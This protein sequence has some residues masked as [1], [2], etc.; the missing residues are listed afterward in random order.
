[1]LC[2][3]GCLPL[4]KH[5]TRITATSSTLIDHIY[6]NATTQ[7]ITS[8]IITSDLSDHMPV[9]VLIQ[10]LHKKTNQATMMTRDYKSFEPENFMTDL[11]AELNEI[12]FS[13]DLLPSGDDFA[14]FLQIF[15]DILNKHAPLRKKTR[16]EVKLGNK[17]WI[18]KGI[19]KSSKTKSKLYQTSL[20][21]KLDDINLY[22]T[23]RNKLTHIK[24]LSKKEYYSQ[25]VKDSKHNIT[26]L[27]RTINDITK[28][29]FKRKSKLQITELLDE[30][31]MKVTDQIKIANLFNDFFSEVG[32]KM[33]NK[34]D[35]PSA[36][37]T[38][39]SNPLTENRC[40]SF[41]FKPITTADILAHIQQLNVNKCAGP[42]EIPIRVIKM[43]SPV[44][45]PILEL[46]FNK[47]LT[48][49]SFPRSLKIGKIVPIHKKGP[50]NE[51]CNYRPI[52]L[53]SPLSKIFEKC[54][55]KQMY[56]YL[57]KYNLLTPNQF[58]FRQN[59]STSLAVRQ[60]YDNF[61]ESLDKKK[62]TC[63]VFIDL[64]KAFDTV[65]HEI[66][67]KKLLRYGFRGLPLQ[68][69]Q[70]YL[71]NRNQYAFVN[72][73][74]SN[75]RRVK[76]GVPQG[77]TLG[78][79]LFLI[80]VNDLPYVSD[81]TTKLFAD[82]TV[83]TMANS[84]MR[85][86]Q[87]DVNKE[88][89]KIDEWMRLNKL[90]LNYSKT[91][92]MLITNKTK[93]EDLINGNIT[94]G[95]HKIEQVTQIKYLGVTFDNKLTWKPH[96]QEICS[97]LSSGSWAILK[98]RQYIDLQTLKAVYFSLIYSHLQ[99][100][101]SAWGLA[102]ADALNPL[103]KLHKRIIRNM[104]N[105][106]YREHTTPLFFKLNLLKIHDICNLEIAKNMFQI[107]NKMT[108]HDSQI[109]HLATHIHKHRT[110]FSSRE[111]YFIP[112]KRTEYGKKSFSFMGPK[113]WQIVPDELKLLP[114]NRF[115]TK[116]KFHF[117]SKYSIDQPK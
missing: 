50:K 87:H 72:G 9:S 104:T 78:P 16:K 15:V 19:L 56:T 94:I 90:S 116:L 103:E 67:L 25:L 38:T 33:A 102:H 42:E 66:L 29:K 4:I 3:S 39:F 20:S 54:I 96:I 70:S 91:K 80:Y 34:I 111:N 61:L 13:S 81:F 60:L 109:F 23:Y 107:K 21:G 85:T 28:F 98:L 62:I 37:N 43:S 7:N 5:P 32:Q 64:S 76:C 22:K 8:Y 105:S 10:N 99:Y 73:T 84:C 46:L 18:T 31:D 12:D 59:C 6:T 113:V 47:C 27:W 41:F 11:S 55:Y 89:T 40:N 114:F 49:G 44:I 101:I 51:C 97:K 57:E 65:D 79:L 86:L 92:Y 88:L 83:L 17:P 26:V 68:L 77:S 24:E 110:R 36:S 1:M 69:I 58:G 2:S 35:K 30:A 112:R 106:P 48:N 53:L 95:K 71:T 117:I 93:S 74:K 75:L 82:D 63:S 52:T 14:I 108:Q 115:K 100:C 45:A